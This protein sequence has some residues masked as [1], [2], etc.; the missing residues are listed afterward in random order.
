MV[1]LEE[2]LK[3]CSMK[4]TYHNIPQNQSYWHHVFFHHVAIFLCYALRYSVITSL[5]S[6]HIN[7]TCVFFTLHDEQICP[8]MGV[9]VEQPV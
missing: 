6:E 2:M 4:C 1:A 8:D 5:P 9:N 3:L 7:F